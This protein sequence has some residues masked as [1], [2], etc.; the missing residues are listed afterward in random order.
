[1][2]GKFS[3]KVK[4]R[5]KNFNI[6]KKLDAAPKVK[7]GIT[8]KEHKLKFRD[9]DP[10]LKAKFNAEARG[11]SLFDSIFNMFKF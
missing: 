9:L 10:K 4:Y 11:P 5:K 2:S 1:M 8:I 7:P 3:R 6:Y